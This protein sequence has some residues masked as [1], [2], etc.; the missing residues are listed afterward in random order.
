MFKG[1][2]L[3][4]ISALITKEF[5]QIIRDPSSLL[6]SVVLP[7]ILLFVYGFG[8]SLDMDNLRIGL[9]M[10][11]TAPDAQSFADHCLIHPILM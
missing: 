5:Y 2:S 1:G 8:V 11:D 3:R 9:V 10:E 7:L 6:I 4:R